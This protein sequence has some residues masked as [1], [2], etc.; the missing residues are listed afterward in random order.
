MDENKP[1]TATTQLAP[2]TVT[3]LVENQKRDLEIRAG[4]L[5]L[6]AQE[7]AHAFAHAGK[8]LEAEERDRKDHRQT[9]LR[10]ARLRYC[11]IAILTCLSLA[12]VLALVWFGRDQLAS[13]IV[14]MAASLATGAIGGFYY[15]RHQESKSNSNSTN[16]NTSDE[17]DD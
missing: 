8:A 5:Q 12:F 1:D 6:K 3:Q 14:K 13:E 15:G 16:S 4:E 10:G 9:Q 7:D 17:A 2:G 11:F